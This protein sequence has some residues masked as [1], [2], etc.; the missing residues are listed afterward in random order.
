[1]SLYSRLTDLRPLPHAEQYLSAH[2]MT[3]QSFGKGGSWENVT[4][5][6]PVLNR[7]KELKA[8]FV[9]VAKYG[10]LL[11]E[12]DLRDRPY[13]EDAPRFLIGRAFAQG[14]FQQ[15]A[16][17]QLVY[18]DKYSL[19]KGLGI[20]NKHYAAQD[21]DKLL[22]PDDELSARQR[23]K[24]FSGQYVYA[25]GAQGLSKIGEGSTD[26]IEKW[27]DEAYPADVR[28]SR[29]FCLGHGAMLMCGMK[30]QAGLN[31]YLIG[32]ASQ[33]VDLDDEVV[34]ILSRDKTEDN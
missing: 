18:S 12:E 11:S 13:S 24:T 7:D 9:A 33:S 29:A 28:L 2:K 10:L 17:S 21:F 8:Q 5:Q 1:M 3:D 14:F 6:Y 26:Y 34:S 15:V 22:D 20:L 31:E 32:V 19:A 23:L 27:A 16:P 25:L 4:S 30:Y